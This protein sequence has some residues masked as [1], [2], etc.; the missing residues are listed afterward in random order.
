MTM[1]MAMATWMGASAMDYK[2]AREQAYY[3]TDKM[4]YELNLNDQQYNDA[5]EINLDYLM[6]VNTVDDVYSVC[7]RQR[8]ADLHHILLDWQ[9]TAFCAASYFFRPLYWSAGCWHFSV[10][11]HYP[12]RN[13]YYFSRPACYVSYRGGHSWRHNGGASWYVHRA[14]TYRNPARPHVGLRDNYRGSGRNHAPARGMAHNS[15]RDGHNTHATQQRADRGRT[16]AQDRD[17]RPAATAPNRGERGSYGQQNSN[18]RRTYNRESS[19]RTTVG[20][21]NRPTYRGNSSPSSNGGN[22]RGNSSR[23][24][25]PGNTATSRGGSSFRG[26][27]NGSQGNAANHGGRR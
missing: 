22:F 3:L 6:D 1:M 10:Y 16:Y 2:T 24:V 15:Y 17:N 21:S 26:T 12:H 27:Q 23:S 20:N 4:A 7:W 14:N 9:Y 25:S 5:Y 19:T 11:A 8:N 13:F 18:D